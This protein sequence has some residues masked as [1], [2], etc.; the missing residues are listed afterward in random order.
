[1]HVRRCKVCAG[2]CTMRQPRN[3]DVALAR[4]E[5]VAGAEVDDANVHGE[6]ALYTAARHAPVTRSSTNTR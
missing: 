4:A 3:G 2:M 6:T 1:M 5:L